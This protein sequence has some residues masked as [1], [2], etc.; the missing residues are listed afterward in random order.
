[1]PTRGRPPKASEES[2]GVA[3]DE[4]AQCWAGANGF[5]WHGSARRWQKTPPTAMADPPNAP[6]SMPTASSDPSAPPS[7]SARERKCLKICTYNY[8]GGVGKTTI[9]INTAAALAKHGLKVRAK[10]RVQLGCMQYVRI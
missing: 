5:F 4:E 9:T 3:Y 8:K 2:G 7:T 6:T 1:M 10:Q